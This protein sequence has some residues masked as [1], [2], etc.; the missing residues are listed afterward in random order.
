MERG[1]RIGGS[2]LG[3][4][5]GDVLGCPVEF[6]PAELIAQV[7]GRYDTLPSAYPLERIPGDPHIR[8]HLRPLGL[9]SDDTQQALTLLQLC[10]KR[11]G[12]VV[13]DWGQALRDGARAQAWRGT[14]KNFRAAVARLES[15]VDAAHSGS[16]SAG[17]GAAMRIAPI[18]AIYHANLQELERVVFEATR[19]VHNDACA[20]AFAF[21]VAQACALLVEGVDAAQVRERLPAD[22]AAFE[23][24]RLGAYPQSERHAV[25]L[26]L[27][28]VLAAAHDSLGQLR[29]WLRARPIVTTVRPEELE[30]LPNHP[31]ALV[32]GVHALMVGLWPEGDPAELLADAVRQGGDADTIGAICGG[33]LGARFGTA[34][35]PTPRMLD[36]EA[37]VAY[38]Q[39][40]P[41]EQLPESLEQLLRREAEWT[42]KEHAFRERLAKTSG[43]ATST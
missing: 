25:S 13:N 36:A 21:A 30:Q 37:L 29:S 34:W 7:F 12:F 18:G 40:L 33:I 20:I 15:G 28:V 35:L 3:L 4:A 43:G 10:L 38:A 9:H 17:I 24:R 2:L 6:W 8:G 32:G 11:G 26:E 27:G 14:G 31:L 19:T 23:A 22:V 5:W 41:E 42:Q 16:P 1:Q 39:A